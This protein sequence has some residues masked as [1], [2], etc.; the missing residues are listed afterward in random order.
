MVWSPE[1]RSK[2]LSRLAEIDAELRPPR[3]HQLTSAQRRAL[4][5]EEQAL[6]E[7]YAENLP[8]R[9]VSRCPIC[10]QVLELPIDDAGLDGPWWWT[11]CPV[12]LPPPRGC[13]HFQVFLGALDLHGRTPAEVVSG[14]KPGPGAPFVIERLL[15]MEGMQAVLSTVPVGAADT[16]YI[17]AYYSPEP[18]PE[19]EL[20]QPWRRETWELH[21]DTGKPV[22]SNHVNDPWD[23]DL[24]PWIRK[25]KLLWI[26]PGDGGL[27]LRKELP[28][29]YDALA[30]T[31]QSQELSA[32][33]VL[34]SKPPDGSE[35]AIWE[36][37]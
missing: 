10:E 29:P 33:K 9:E 6:L 13:E 23:F 24:E 32:G 27:V 14:V 26:A 4:R 22:A 20:H 37:A 15:S 34:L 5:Q 2:L 1:E 28:S 17:I 19:P 11:V 7:E 31:H 25:G 8:V 18:V 12:E 35:W 16:G 30:G 36:R 21:D 3:S